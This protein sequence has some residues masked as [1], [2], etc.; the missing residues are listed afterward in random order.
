MTETG[1]TLE[2]L[3]MLRNAVLH[4]AADL[5]GQQG[6][7]PRGSRPQ[8]CITQALAAVTGH[9]EGTALDS[10]PEQV[11]HAAI[12]AILHRISGAYITDIFAWESQTGRTQDEVVALLRSA[13][14]P[15][16]HDTKW[17]KAC[18]ENAFDRAGDAIDDEAW[19][20]E[21]PERENEELYRLANKVRALPVR[22]ICWCGRE[23]QPG[24]DHAMCWP[25]M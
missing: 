4:C 8:L 13:A 6:W 10:V 20:H 1:G 9:D 14:E 19:P 23:K 12:L 24:E 7:S 5:I 21:R 17:A 25:G 22:D 2:H 3:P 15:T 11:S 18:Q 16:E